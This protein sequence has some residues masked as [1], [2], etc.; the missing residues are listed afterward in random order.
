[1]SRFNMKSK[2]SKEAA[3]KATAKGGVSNFKMEG[4]KANLLILGEVDGKP[5]VFTARHHEIWANK[6]PVS[7]YG[8]PG[9][10][11]ET[12]KVSDLG[13]KLRDKYKDNKND[14][15]KDFF[16]KFLPKTSHVVNVL[17]LDNLD[18]G[19]QV[20]QMSGAVSE[21]VLEEFIDMGDDQTSIC[22][23]DEG[24]ILEI[25]TNGKQGLQKRYKCKFL[26]E[27]AGLL[28]NNDI[29]EEELEDIA[30]K[31]Y[32]LTKLQQAYTKEAEEKHLELLAKAADK[33]GINIDDLVADDDNS[34]D[35]FEEA[36]NDD[37]GFDDE[38]D[39]GEDDDNGEDEFDDEEEPKKEEPKKRQ[40]SRS[41]GKKEDTKTSTR[42]RRRS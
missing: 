35:E 36:E 22:D 21:V 25:K 19:P 38:I 28:E 42:R 20:Y 6:R 8:A 37:D 18:R 17:D 30:D 14:K 13:W 24:R 29:S 23:F 1:M 33:L 4:K 40:R 34:D 41:A 11:G 10:D 12:D 3:K 5:A 39:T 16:K 15:K 7:K 32:D 27:T 9:V 31:T 2:A 26:A